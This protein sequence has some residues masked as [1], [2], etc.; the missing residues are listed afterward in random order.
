M[1]K[2]DR[3]PEGWMLA[4]L[5]D[6]AAETMN[7]FGKRSQVDGTPTI[8]LRLAD[9]E[10]GEVRLDSVRHINAKPGEINDYRLMAN[11]LLAIRVNGSPDLV[12]RLIRVKGTDEPVLF[13]DHFIRLRLHLP[14]MAPFVRYFSETPAVRRYVDHNKVCS[15]GQNTISQRTLGQIALPVPALAEQQRIVAKI[16]ELFSDLDAGVAAMERVRAKLKR[17]RAAVLDAAVAGKLIQTEDTSWAEVSRWKPLEEVIENLEQ[18]WSPRCERESGTG[19]DDWAVMTTTAIQPMSFD[20][21]ENK[22]LPSN[23]KPRPE[24]EV[25]AGDV[26]ITRAGPRNRA[27]IACCVKSTRARLI[28]CDKAYRFTCKPA[29]A[30]GG[31]IELVLN[32]RPMINALSEMKTGISDSGVNLT[33]SRF[34]QLRIPLPPMALQEKI[35]AEV[36]RRVSVIE[37]V[38]LEVEHGLKRGVRLRQAIL[39]RA[40]EGKLVSQD[41]SDEPARGLV[42]RIAAQREGPS[43]VQPRSNLRRLLA[44]EKS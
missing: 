36:Q 18:G 10:N 17:Y 12:G 5:S 32:A 16:E 44:K 23:L 13:C 26:L 35:V 19:A 3:L 43:P 37:A 40:F 33:Q 15:A 1:T 4:K 9:I 21:S 22:R 2:T 38:E 24:L 29:A 42:N 14:D 31:Y 11:D 41:A 7:G 25:R 28:L 20:S 8:V 27:G 39:K 30:T 6:L 34:R